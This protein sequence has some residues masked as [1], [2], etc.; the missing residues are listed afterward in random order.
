MITEIQSTLLNLTAHALFN[1][2][3]HITESV[4]WP[5]VFEEAYAQAVVPIA[6]MAAK[7]FIP[8]DEKKRWESLSTRVIGNSIRMDYEHVEL[9]NLMSEAGIPYVAMKG[10][11]S[12]WYYPE[13]ILR[14]MGD[15][16]FLVKRE[17]LGRTAKALESAGFRAVEDNENQAHIGYH[18]IQ[19]RISSTWEMHWSLAGI[20]KGEAGDM[21]RNYLEDMIE[22]AVEIVTPDGK[23]MI[24]DAFHHGLIMLIHTAGHMINTGVGL[25]HLCD[26]A[27]FVEKFSDEEFRDIFENKLKTAGLWHF[28][29]LLTQLSIQYLGCPYKKW[30]M[31][32]VNVSLIESILT[33]IFAGG[34]FGGK[35]PERINQAK[36]IT[37]QRKNNVDDSSMIK[38]LFS[39]MNEKARIGMPV[40]EKI[41]ALLPVGWIYVGGRHIGRILAGE[42]PKIHVGKMIDGAS[43]R[44]EIYKQFRLFEAE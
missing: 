15:V 34:N 24:P 8:A 16:D 29:R 36:L 7:P 27:V 40:C 35:D 25:R 6:Y 38:Q 30:A 5:S 21:V 19:G 13:P 14:T 9:H 4:D 37:D 31:E 39:T 22:T 32:D 26:W 1:T 17:D 23:Y 10:S 41:P 44:K 28:A 3:V 33:D 43:E 2:P 18:R 42:R 11:A 12:A 20:P